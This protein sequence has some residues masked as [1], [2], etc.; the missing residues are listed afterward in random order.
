MK[1]YV[2]WHKSYNEHHT[3]T[4]VVNQSYEKNTPQNHWFTD[5]PFLAGLIPLQTDSNYTIEQI[6]KIKKFIIQ[7]S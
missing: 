6:K 7:S 2:E 4:L 1:Q 5:Q 3:T